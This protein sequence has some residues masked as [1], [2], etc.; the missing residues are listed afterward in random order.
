MSK[1]VEILKEH[2]RNA[3]THWRDYVET[4]KK[5]IPIVVGDDAAARE[6]LRFVN[7]PIDQE[8]TIP[9][10]S[11]NFGTGD[12]YKEKKAF[13]K[14]MQMLA[15]S[16]CT[17]E[18]QTMYTELEKKDISNELTAAFSF[19]QLTALDF[20]HSFE[21]DH[22]NWVYKGNPMVSVP[23]EELKDA[24]KFNYSMELLEK[25]EEKDKI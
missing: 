5:E 20:I 15:P 2:Y 12:F 19:A 17:A 1:N 4:V 6:F 9:F 3:M 7:Q 13:K 25:A 24:V 16:E 11:W 8:M 23:W 18:I 14:L 10:T 22:D 21:M